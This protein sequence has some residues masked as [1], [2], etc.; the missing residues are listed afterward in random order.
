MA[1]A[2]AVAALSADCIAFL[3]PRRDML[4]RIEAGNLSINCGAELCEGPRGSER[5]RAREGP[6][7]SERVRES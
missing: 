7:R 2:A 3:L 5:V 4:N 1:R 6:R